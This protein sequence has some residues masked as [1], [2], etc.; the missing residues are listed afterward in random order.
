MAN[1]GGSRA[2]KIRAALAP[3]VAS[4]TAICWRCTEPIRSDDEWDVGHKQGRDAGGDPWAL[5]NVAPEHRGK[6]NRRD[7]ANIT[8]AKR[9]RK[10][11]RIR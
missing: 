11:R 5:T 9:S 2:T 7:G 3:L 8:N 4:G 10:A 6:C 1:W